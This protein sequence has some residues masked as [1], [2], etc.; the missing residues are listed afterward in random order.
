MKR[1]TYVV[2]AAAI[3]TLSLTAS[4]GTRNGGSSVPAAAGPVAS[5]QPPQ[6][7]RHDPTVAPAVR[8]VAPAV[9][10]KPDPLC[11]NVGVSVDGLLRAIRVGHHAT[12]DRVVFEFCGSSVPQHNLGYITGPVHADPS[13]L[14]VPL[15]GH[16]FVGVVFH[17][18]TTDTA[19]YAPDPTTAPRYSGPVRLTPN[20]ALLK[21]LACAGDFEA[22]LSFGIGLDRVAGIHVQTLTAPARLV[23]DFRSV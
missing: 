15:R 21:E 3:G 13:D 18:A 12:Y 14:I 2:V 19:R 9:A 5:A 7:S 17:N 11:P 10:P 20:Y 16:A 23:I 4:C 1:L 8:P 6:P 22:V